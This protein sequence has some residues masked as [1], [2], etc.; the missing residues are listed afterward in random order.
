MIF[1]S[2]LRYPGWKKKLSKFLAKI[3]LDNNINWHYVEPYAWWA[4]VALYLLI[5]R[6]V[7][8]ITIND[9][10]RSIY[11]FWY[12]V[13]YETDKLISMIKESDI[14]I[15]NRNI[16]KDIQNNKDKVSLLN[17]WFSTLFLNRTN[18]SWI[19]NAW[20][21]W[22]RMQN[23]KYKID[24]RFNKEDVIKKIILIAS[25]KNKITL[26]NLDALDLIKKIRKT[27][28]TIFYFDPPYYL[29]WK[30]LYL[31]AYNWDDHEKVCNAI[32]KLKNVKWVVSYDDVAE[33]RNLYRP[34]RKIQY[35]FTH[36][37]YK[38]REWLE[39]LFFSNNLNKI[40]FNINPTLT[41]L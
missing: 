30:S 41:R 15:E 10:D 26:E 37:A 7:N 32:K 29:K 27:K 33:I 14:T 20:P 23:W 16:Q 8:R 5:D 34:F 9:K 38:A 36:T 3:C 17:L 6:F 28:N 24:C 2:P 35:S 18:R 31:N 1:Y 4:S 22:W 25:F 40:D 39:I 19:I 13:L 12:S 11:A 21:I